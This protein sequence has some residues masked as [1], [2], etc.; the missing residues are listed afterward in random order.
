M[1]LA[2]Q[3]LIEHRKELYDF[4]D[5]KISMRILQTLQGQKIMTCLTL[6]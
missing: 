5:G 4:S 6:F 2:G 3:R 1:I